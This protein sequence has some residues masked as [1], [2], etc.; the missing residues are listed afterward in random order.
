MVDKLKHRLYY[1]HIGK[2][3]AHNMNDIFE[4]I[5]DLRELQKLYA[6]GEVCELDFKKNPKI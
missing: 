3:E 4:I 5:D 6:T 1:I 2:Q